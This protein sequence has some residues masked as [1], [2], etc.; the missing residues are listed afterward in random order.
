MAW[1]A[2]DGKDNAGAVTFH[3]LDDD[4][5]KIM[6]QMDFEPGGRSR[7]SAALG[8]D[9]RRV[10]GD[11]ERFKELVESRRAETG[12]WRGEVRQRSRTGGA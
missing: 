1:K 10:M 2:I 9:E 4:R 11:L 8:A 5:T 7:R 3:R 12:A 6:V